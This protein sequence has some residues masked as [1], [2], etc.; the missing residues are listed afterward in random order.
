MISQLAMLLLDELHL[1]P[2]VIN[3]QRLTQK[4]AEQPEAFVTAWNWL[5]AY[6]RLSEGDTVYRFLRQAMMA[7]RALLLIESFH[8]AS[9]PLY[10]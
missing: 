4:I 5:D 10:F 7:R 8:R 2:V 1:V 9:N 6:L 3:V